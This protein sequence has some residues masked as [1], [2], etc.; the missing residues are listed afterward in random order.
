MLNVVKLP[1]VG[2]VT[3]IGWPSIVI[4]M[5]GEDGVATDEPPGWDASGEAGCEPED[6]VSAGL[7]PYAGAEPDGPPPAELMPDGDVP[8][9]LM[10]VG[11]FTRGIPPD[12]APLFGAVLTGF[13]RWKQCQP[14]YHRS[15]QC[16]MG[17]HQMDHHHWGLYPKEWR[18]EMKSPTVCQ[19]LETQRRLVEGHRLYMRLSLRRLKLP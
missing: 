10:P 1:V 14:G 17:H 15:G 6:P 11:V 19:R 9:W 3:V 7:E 16:Q 8:G 4:V 18:L 12:D 5:Q 2:I 13:R